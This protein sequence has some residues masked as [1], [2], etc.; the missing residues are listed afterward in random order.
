MNMTVDHIQG[1]EALTILGLQG[2]LDASS[3]QSVID[4]AVELYQ[5]GTRQLLLDMS[6]V[7]FMSSSGVVALHS[8]ILIFRGEQPHDPE[9]GWEAFHAIDRDRDSEVRSAVKI[10]NPTPKVAL[11]L[12]KTGMD[13]FCEI[14][15]DL[16]T[17]LKSF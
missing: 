2:N 16:N 17:A 1:Q 3:Y 6:E 14:H 12:Q 4:T 11:T 5:Q 8:I 10:L 15:S 9:S 13:Q 7:P